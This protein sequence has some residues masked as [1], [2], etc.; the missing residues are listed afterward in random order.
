MNAIAI[1]LLG[2]SVTGCATTGYMVKRG[3]DAADVFNLAVGIGAG[4]KVRVGPISP[5]IIGRSDYAGLSQGTFFCG[6]HPYVTEKQGF[7][8]WYHGSEG[9]NGL[10]GGER[11]AQ[12]YLTRD[13]HKYYEAAYLFGIA[14]SKNMESDPMTYNP[15]YFTQIDV[16]A[17][18]GGIL[19][20]GFNPGELLDFL[21]G[22]FGVDIYG[23]DDSPYDLPRV[24]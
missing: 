18:L 22:W 13:R 8:D 24:P 16:A 1:S 21:L 7:G 23:D 20:A 5:G 15:S 9:S 4:A 11:A 17:G 14:V 12:Y 2:L 10:L 3:R 19:H 6:N